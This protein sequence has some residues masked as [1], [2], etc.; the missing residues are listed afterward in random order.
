MTSFIKLTLVTNKPIYINPI[1]MVSLEGFDVQVNGKDEKRTRIN[2]VSDV[3]FV[4]V[5]SVEEIIEKVSKILK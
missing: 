3:H 5:E 4:V 1:Q 2:L